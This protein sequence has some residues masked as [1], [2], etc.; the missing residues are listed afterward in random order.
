[1]GNIALQYGPLTIAV[2]DVGGL[3]TTFAWSLLGNQLATATSTTG[4]ASTLVAAV[5]AAVAAA[6]P[7]VGQFNLPSGLGF[8]FTNPLSGPNTMFPAADSPGAQGSP[9]DDDF[10]GN[11]LQSKWTQISNGAGAAFGFGRGSATVY[12]APL[13]AVNLCAITTPI[14]SLSFEVTA[15]INVNGIQATA[16]I[17]GMLLSDGTKYALVGTLTATNT[18]TY[19]TYTTATGTFASVATAVVGKRPQYWRINYALAVAANVQYNWS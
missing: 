2:Q 7:V 5:N 16:P 9:V 11:Y 15:K 13:V 19:A 17:A 18:V 4:S 3:G 1:M 6:T 14:P 10:S 12:P 8:S